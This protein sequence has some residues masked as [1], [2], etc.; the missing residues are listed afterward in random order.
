MTVST[1]RPK[2]TIFDIDTIKGSEKKILTATKDIRK[3]F[4][5]SRGFGLATLTAITTY[6]DPKRGF[7][8]REEFESLLYE[9]LAHGASDIFISPDRP[10]T[11][12]KDLDL[13]SLT[14][15][16]IN[17]D[18]A[19][20]ILQ[21]IAGDNAYLV[22][23]NNKY[24]NKAYRILKKDGT[25]K[26]VRHNFRVN[27]S[28]T[29]FRGSGDSFQ[30]TLRTISG[31]PPHFSKLGLDE[32]FL[33]SSLPH[34]GCYIIGGVTGSG[35]STTLASNIRYVLENDTHIRGNILTH[36]EPIEYE[37]DSIQSSHSIVSQSEIPNN[38]E[39][40]ADAN[41][42]A[43]RRRP[44][45]VEIGELRDRE[46]I[47][48]ALEL[49]LTGHPVFATVH[50]TTVDKI[51]PRMLKRF[52]HE[53]HLQ[54]AADII[55]SVYTLIAQRLVKDVNG[56]VFAVR[57]H[58]IFSPQLKEKL[59]L[60]DDIQAQQNF[61]RNLMINSD[62]TDPNISKSFRKQADDL[63]AAGRLHED[64]YHKLIY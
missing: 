19:L 15:R 49:S 22:L 33:I 5:I 46:T 16:N 42:E 64:Y 53:E 26:E 20:Q 52:K 1:L 27:V 38:F 37:Y 4:D 2:S 58:L 25:G 17:R 43:M 28:R 11:M 41:R 34:N 23:M 50:A 7:K 10:I 60:I 13:Y 57:E 14:H 51:I 31:V 61:I 62:G 55:G 21:T 3:E 54:A 30:I 35:K 45:A 39:T 8:T 40:F 32:D 59:I 56:K 12:M 48:A 24:T 63:R 36:N 44:A 9:A 29:S 18:E 47:S 6:K